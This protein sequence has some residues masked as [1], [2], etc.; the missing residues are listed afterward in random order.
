MP[1]THIMPV[2]QVSLKSVPRIREYYSYTLQLTIRCASML[3]ACCTVRVPN[4]HQAEHSES[5]TDKKCTQRAPKCLLLNVA[6][7]FYTVDIYDRLQSY[8]HLPVLY[9][10]FQQ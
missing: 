1:D 9:R 4:L 10:M 6:L 5:I 3:S 8:K 2:H 7:P